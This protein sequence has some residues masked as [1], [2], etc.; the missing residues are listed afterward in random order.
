[1]RNMYVFYLFKM[2]MLN[3]ES[4]IVNKEKPKFKNY[5]LKDGEISN[6]TVT[7]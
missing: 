2:I 5:S 4:V 1:M 7:F 3:A 6:V